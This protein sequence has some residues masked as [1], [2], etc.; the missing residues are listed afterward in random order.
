MTNG[1][2]LL[3]NDPVID[4]FKTCINSIRCRHPSLPICVIPFNTDCAEVHNFCRTNNLEWFDD[5][6]VFRQIREFCQQ[7]YRPDRE[8]L[9]R[10]LCCWMGPFDQFIHI[11]VDVV[12]GCDLDIFW[13]LIPEYGDVIVGHRCGTSGSKYV[14]RDT[15]HQNS[16]LTE[17]QISFCGNMGCIVGR[18]NEPFFEY[19]MDSWETMNNL[20][21]HLS[22]TSDQPC[23]NYWMVTY[24]WTYNAMEH[25]RRLVPT[26]PFHAWGFN[27]AMTMTLDG[28]DLYCD[29]IPTAFVHWAGLD[30]DND[31]HD[32]NHIWNHYKNLV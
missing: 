26:L 17:H 20:L 6:E 12:V 2:Y 18:K 29:G 4:Q 10:K 5:I 16:E 23:L 24:D 27:V 28:N 15:I 8:G 32:Y 11:D 19:C 9:F 31:Q 22:D 25:I 1:I 14:W 13:D 3:A 21:P 30:P 7:T